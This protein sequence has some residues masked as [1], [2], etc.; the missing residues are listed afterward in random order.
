MDAV[1]PSDLNDEQW[2][3]I[4]RLIPSAL[5]GGRPRTVAMRQVLNAIFYV[6]RAG[7]AWR[8][9]PKD[10]PPWQTVYYY[11]RRFKRDGT[12]ERIHEL[13]RKRVRVQNGKKEQPSAAVLD[14]QSTKTTEK[15]APTDT[16]RGRRSTVGSGIFSWTHSG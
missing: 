10:Y 11:F 5:P 6:A 16:T 7:C 8:M 9:L 15:G 14:S 13:L 4:R 1:Y 2:E 12:W 3:A